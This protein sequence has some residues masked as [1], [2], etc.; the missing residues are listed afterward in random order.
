VGK[1]KSKRPA[2]EKRRIE[3][4][5]RAIADERK[6]LAALEPGG[7][8][9]RPLQVTTAATVES[10]ARARGCVHCDGAMQ[11]LAHDSE[12]VGDRRLR[13]VTLR[14]KQCQSERL[15]WVEIAPALPS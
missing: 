14:C 5:L 2:V 1:R 13:R 9:E 12:T 10:R 15:V 8:P 4:K 6:K 3:K 11:V 7:S